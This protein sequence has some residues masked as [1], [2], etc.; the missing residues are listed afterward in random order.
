MKTKP[1]T[2]YGMWILTMIVISS[3]FAFPGC[4]DDKETNTIQTGG[5]RVLP[6]EL[7]FSS[8]GGMQDVFLVLTDDVDPSALSYEVAE[9]GE[10][11]CTVELVDKNL[12]VTVY[13]TYYDYPRSTV[14]TLNYGSLKREIPISQKA[15][16]GAEDLKLLVASATATTQEIEQEQRGI[17]KSFD[18]D[19]L[20]YFNSKFGAFADWPFIIEYT[21]KEAGTLDYI[22][23]HPRTDSGTRY[24]AFNQ[25]EVWVA[26]EDNPSAYTKVGTYDRGDAN[27]TVTTMR[28]EASV[29]KA[30]KI[31]FV[32]NSAHNNR[33][34]CA[35]MEFFQVSVNKFDYLKIFTDRSCSELRPEIIEADIKKIP[36]TEYKQLATALLNKVYNADYRVA[37]YRPYQDPIV[38]ASVNKT[39]PYS[40]RDNP[41]GIYAETGEELL[42]LVGDTHG[43]NI[44][45]VVQDLSVGYGS[46]K[47]YPLSE[48]GNK[49]KISSGGLIYI[50]NLTKDNIPLILD[51]EAAKAAALAKTVKVHIAFGKVNGYFD[52]Q[53][54]TASDWDNILKTA[55]YKDIDVLGKYAHITWTVQNFKDNNTDIVTVLQKYDRLVYL[56]QEFMGLEKYN[57]MFNNRMYFHVDYNGASPYA[58]SN[59]TA[60]TP[61]Y[62][63]IFCNAARFEARLWGPAH[64]VGHCNQTRPGLKWAGTTEVTNN[65]HSMYIQQQFGEK[66]KLLVDGTYAAATAAII[67]A[68]QPH[69]LNN[70]SDEF[71]LK[72]VPFWQ[73]KL[74]M[75]E[76][77]GK[78]DFYKD[79]YEHYRI[80]TN[81]N[82]TVDTEG[83]LQLD[84]VR[85]VCRISG[86][87]MLDFFQKWGF[88]RPVDKVINDYGNKNFRIIQAQIDA[89]EKEI[90]A[91]NYAMPHANVHQ[92]TEDNINGYRN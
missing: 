9:N 74:Y 89:L 57:K 45:M 33:I 55:K 34:S 18:N 69:C 68:N 13:P 8:S 40:L 24:G 44:S 26:T 66:S 37:L 41:T 73:L 29:A 67:T 86:L 38:M 4:S 51:T 90:K 58:S 70:A 27:Y 92:I 25:Y 5:V 88:L 19:Y 7:D 20:T 12:K 78:T 23:Y 28:L 77:Q 82:T 43:Q 80:T 3:L 48:G 60:Y 1:I 11:W 6:L 56:E 42:V 21:L 63:E 14:V 30:K 2:M 46:S 62:A 59:R 31:K 72:L 53:K 84:F 81:L 35:E 61:G 36:E 47:T 87:N 49:I 10:D 79:L 32:I 75:L 71:V 39:S 17:D 65:I 16:E 22:V 91:A 64:E 54:H 85:Q 50:L 52:S 15:S 76:A 83:I